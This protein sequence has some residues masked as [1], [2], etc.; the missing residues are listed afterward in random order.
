MPKLAGAPCS[1]PQRDPPADRAHAVGGRLVVSSAGPGPVLTLLLP[2]LGE[3]AREAP[4]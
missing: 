4:V 1:P 3:P 2:S